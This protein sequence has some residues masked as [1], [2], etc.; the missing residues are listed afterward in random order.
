MKR[1]NRLLIFLHLRRDWAN[2]IELA[3]PAFDSNPHAYDPEMDGKTLTYCATCGG[4]PKHPIH[5]KPSIWPWPP[6][7]KSPIDSDDIARYPRPK[8]EV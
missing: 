1:W 7:Q 5:T 4:G 2:E 8:Q 3:P 6:H